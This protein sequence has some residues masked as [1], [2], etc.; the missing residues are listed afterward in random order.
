MEPDGS[1]RPVR[2][3][4]EWGDRLATLASQIGDDTIGATRV[5]T[6]FLGI[7]HAWDGGPPILFET[8]IFGGSHDEYQVRYRTHAEAVAG[9][10]RALK[11][12]RESLP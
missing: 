12:V 9:H 4:A 10:A 6:V 8:M 11:M 7:D 2:D 1:T 5:S 3:L